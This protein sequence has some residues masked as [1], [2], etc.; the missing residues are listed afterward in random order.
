MHLLELEWYPERVHPEGSRL[1]DRMCFTTRLLSPPI[2][3][4]KQARRKRGRHHIA[5]ESRKSN[6]CSLFAVVQKNVGFQCDLLGID[7]SNCS[8]LLVVTTSDCCSL[9][10]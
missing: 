1:L 10:H 3:V 6:G 2:A 8:V 5:C 9:P 7:H 4:S